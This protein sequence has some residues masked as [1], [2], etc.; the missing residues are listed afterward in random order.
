MTPKQ[1]FWTVIATLFVWLMLLATEGHSAPPRKPYVVRMYTMTQCPTCDH[2]KVRLKSMDQAMR[3]TRVS[4]NVSGSTSFP[5]VVY[6]DAACDFGGRIFRDEVTT[7]GKAVQCYEW[8]YS[9]PALSVL[10][11]P[12]R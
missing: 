1:A 5:T 7:S 10:D 9:F 3:T 12:R 4:R 2:V 8:Q 11:A 6:S